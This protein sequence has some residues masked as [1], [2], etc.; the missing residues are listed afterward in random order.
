MR[1]QGGATGPLVL[2]VVALLV[3]LPIFYVLSV[4][5]AIWL[6]TRDYIPQSWVGTFY[7][8]LVWACEHCQPLENFVSW[9]DSLFS[10]SP[11]VVEYT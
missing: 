11:P 1:N 4:G 9:Y 5:P 6:Y 7:A 8:P 3:L 10:P 2:I